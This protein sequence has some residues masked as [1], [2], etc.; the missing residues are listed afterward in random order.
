[1]G[2]KMGFYCSS[3]KSTND[4][5]YIEIKSSTVNIDNAKNN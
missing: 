1:V 5:G 3:E 2:A 4:A